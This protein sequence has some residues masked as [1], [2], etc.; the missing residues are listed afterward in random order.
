MWGAGKRRGWSDCRGIRCGDVRPMG[1]QGVRSRQA[2]GS[3][4]GMDGKRINKE[5]GVG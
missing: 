3:A 4:G 5:G 2:G 1:V